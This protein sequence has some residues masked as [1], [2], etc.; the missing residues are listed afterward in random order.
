KLRRIVFRKSFLGRFEG[1]TAE[2]QYR[3]IGPKN[4]RDVKLHPQ[5]ACGAE[6][7]EGRHHRHEEH[8][9]GN[10]GKDNG[11]RIASRRW[12]SVRWPLVVAAAVS[13]AIAAIRRLAA[14]AVPNVCKD[15][16]EFVKNAWSWHDL[17]S[18][19]PSNDTS[20]PVPAPNAGG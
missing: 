11:G 12:S 8:Q 2:D 5:A 1:H 3:R 19:A 10:H 13:A 17:A 15:Q 9:D 20:R 14:P 6:N 7:Q 18:F 16:L 4:S